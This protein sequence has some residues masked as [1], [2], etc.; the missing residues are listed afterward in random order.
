MTLT[1]IFAIA[2]AL[3]LG[4]ALPQT[5]HPTC[6]DVAQV[7]G[8]SCLDFTG[9][10]GVPTAVFMNAGSFTPHRERDLVAANWGY[11]NNDEHLCQDDYLYFDR[12]DKNSPSADECARVRDWLRANKGRFYVNDGMQQIQTWTPLVWTDGCAFVTNS[13]GN[14][15]A[16]GYYLGNKDVGD[17]VD[18][19]VTNHAKD[20]KVEGRGDRHCTDGGNNYVL[21]KFW[22]LATDS[23]PNT[24]QP[25]T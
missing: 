24:H 3:G 21:V 5:Q 25:G 19:A 22:L 2:I 10:D 9:S 6:K 23:I 8:V 17:V 4:A 11:T 1:V 12:H 18:D 16:N 13:P 15:S 14:P 20:G 7:E